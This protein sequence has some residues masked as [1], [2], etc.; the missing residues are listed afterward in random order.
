MGEKV[1]RGRVG[2]ED[3]SENIDAVNNNTNR[4]YTNIKFCTVK[5]TKFSP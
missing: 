2:I 3:D 4:K 1:G 5:T